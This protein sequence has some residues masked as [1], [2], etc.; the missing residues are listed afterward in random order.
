MLISELI[1]ELS[2][3]KEEFGDIPV[4]ALDEFSCYAEVVATH[5]RGCS[6]VQYLPDI[7]VMLDVYKKKE[8]K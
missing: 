7:F 1:T 8:S 5:L 4:Y 3:H 2:E 6:L